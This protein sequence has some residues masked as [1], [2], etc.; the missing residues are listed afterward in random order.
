[1]SA[2]R[3]D[4]KKVLK[5]AGADGKQI[6][7]LFTDQQIKDE[8][9]LEDISMVLNTGD[10]PN[11]FL[12]EEKADIL[13]RVQGRSCLLPYNQSLGIDGFFLLLEFCPS[14]HRRRSAKRRRRLLRQPVQPLPSEH[15]EEL[16]HRAVHVPHR[17]WI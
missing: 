16:A 2:W 14:Q 6:V 15:Q 9:F 10:V 1:M 13:E 3:N 4:L 12:P 11:L 5:L 8:A 7:F 17:N